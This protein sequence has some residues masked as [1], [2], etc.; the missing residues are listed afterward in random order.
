ML[1][2]T[3]PNC[4]A[5]AFCDNAIAWLAASAQLPARVSKPRALDTLIGASVGAAVGIGVGVDSTRVV[6]GMID[7]VA[8]AVCTRGSSASTRMTRMALFT[9]SIL[10]GGAIQ[11]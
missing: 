3:P 9:A 8:H 11:G 10:Q 4:P 5:A 2:E 7:G 1:N 6:L